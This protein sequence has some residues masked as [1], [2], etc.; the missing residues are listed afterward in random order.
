MSSGR[1]VFMQ[2]FVANVF[3]PKAALFFAG[4]LPQFVSHRYP[5]TPQVW[6]L[7]ITDILTGFL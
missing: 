6:I 1:G 3:N 2:G 4:I 5:M 7:G